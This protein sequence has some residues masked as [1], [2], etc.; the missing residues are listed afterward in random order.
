MIYILSFSDEFEF[1]CG[2]TSVLNPY[3]DLNN[4]Q[5]LTQGNDNKAYHP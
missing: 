5:K 4:M 3:F 1:L 2:L